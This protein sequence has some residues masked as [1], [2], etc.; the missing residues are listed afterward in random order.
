M[1]FVIYINKKYNYMR[2]DLNVLFR[3]YLRT[4]LVGK[5]LHSLHDQPFPPTL[6]FLPNPA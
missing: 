1:E 4:R 2:M 5:Y 3:A 6:L